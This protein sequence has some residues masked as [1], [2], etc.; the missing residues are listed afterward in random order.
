MIQFKVSKVGSDTIMVTRYE[1]INPPIEGLPP[2]Y[3]ST[4]TCKKTELT[5]LINVLN[6]Y[7]N[8]TN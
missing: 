4:L 8:E 5:Q 6:D 7:V 1:P 2:N 3:T